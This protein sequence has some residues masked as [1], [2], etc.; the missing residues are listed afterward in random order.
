MMNDDQK[1]EQKAASA[2]K[3]GA[4]DSKDVHRLKLGGREFI[5][6]G[7]AHIS[8]QSAELV[9][10][11]IEEEKPDTVCV[12]L[13]QRR[14][15][16]I[17]NP[18]Q[19]EK[20]N[21]LEVI[22]KKQL[23]TLVVQLVLASYQKRMGEQ[24]G[25]LPGTELLEATKAATENDIPFELC[26]RDVGIT[27]KRA[28]RNTGFFKRMW[29]LSSVLASIFEPAE[30]SEEQI[31]E[32]KD[33]DA[34]SEMLKEIGEAAPTMK[35]ALIDERDEY[36]AEKI[37]AAKGDRV[38]AVVGAGHVQGMIE[39]LREERKADIGKLEELPPPSHFWRNFG[40]AIPLVIIGSL[41]YIGYT[42]GFDQAMSNLWFWVL[43]NSIPT[44]LGA[45]IALAHPLVIL[46]A[47]LVAP[48]TSL[49]PVVGAGMITAFLQ[50]WL[51]PPRVY[52]LEQAGEDLTKFTHWWTNRL[53]RVFL[54]FFLPGFLGA[55]ATWVGVTKILNSAAG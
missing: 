16:T 45:C 27:L 50:A 29:L 8:R 52:E 31:Q 28:W 18:N 10:R 35:G 15:E 11:V 55:I 36:M 25:V 38:V 21:L 30:V 22:K 43:V 49:T 37:R 3:T 51:K 7:T 41:V 32:I 24:L 39:H 9:R 48:F 26:D 54:T 53:L 17:S 19:W 44:A 6:V 12:E 2:A 40:I 34:L 13:D 14:Y 42:K 46:A 1:D 5:L 4:S 47:F 23:P 33:Q 20:L